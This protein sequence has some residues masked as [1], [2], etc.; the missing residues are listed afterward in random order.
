MAPFLCCFDPQHHELFSQIYCCI[1]LAQRFT[2][3]MIWFSSPGDRLKCVC[4][5]YTYVSMYWWWSSKKDEQ[6]LK[7][8]GKSGRGWPNILDTLNKE[9]LCAEKPPN[10]YL[11]CMQ[12]MRFV[13]PSSSSCVLV[14]LKRK[15]PRGFIWPFFI[16]VMTRRL[17]GEK[18]G[19]DQ[20]RVLRAMPIFN[21]IAPP[22][23][24]CNVY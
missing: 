5:K 16:I 18:P 2:S 6:E 21:I 9:T 22:E 8:E 12:V 7:L 23:V 13:L 15:I 4:S 10:Y 11:Y 3:Q 1:A 17:R 19:D 20:K 24:R 14:Q